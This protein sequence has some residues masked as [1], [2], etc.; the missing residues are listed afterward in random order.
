MTKNHADV[1]VDGH[2]M[3]PRLLADIES[4]TSFVHVSMFFFRDPIGEEVAA[5][6][7]R[8]AKAGVKVRVL[9]FL[10]G[11]TTTTPSGRTRRSTSTCATSNAGSRCTSTRTTSTT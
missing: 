4:A 1:L 11:V 8:R 6:L 7:S 3:L 2:Q 10:R 5:A 9:P